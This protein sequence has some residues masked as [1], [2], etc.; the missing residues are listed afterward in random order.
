MLKIWCSLP[1]HWHIQ[2][3]STKFSWRKCSQPRSCV[4]GTGEGEGC[5]VGCALLISNSIWSNYILTISKCSNPVLQ[6]AREKTSAK[7]SGLPWNELLFLSPCSKSHFSPIGGLNAQQNQSNYSSFFDTYFCFLFA[8]ASHYLK[9]VLVHITK[10]NGKLPLMLSFTICS[11]CNGT[12]ACWFFLQG[13]WSLK[14]KK[15][16]WVQDTVTSEGKKI[17]SSF[18]LI[19]CYRN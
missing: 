18:L 16:R 7:A 6:E 2:D 3:I 4:E 12:S 10:S 14:K 11:C 15:K 17:L 9:V 8:G 19:K 5:S 13:Y 1:R